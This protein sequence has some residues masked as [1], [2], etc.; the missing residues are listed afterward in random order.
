[1]YR[2]GEKNISV[3]YVHVLMQQCRVVYINI[4]IT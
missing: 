3:F 2:S 1:M 4:T